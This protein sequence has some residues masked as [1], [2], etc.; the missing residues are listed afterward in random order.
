MSEKKSP[1]R[2][3]LPED[4]RK[5]TKLPPIYVTDV[6]RARV[7]QMAEDSG[8]DFSNYGRQVFEDHVERV[9]GDPAQPTTEEE[10]TFTVDAEQRKYLQKLADTMNIG[11][12][13]Y[14]ARVAALSLARMDAAEAMDVIVKDMKRVV[15]EKSSKKK[16]EKSATDDELAA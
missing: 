1:G 7:V 3:E 6:F 13:N 11:D 8:E 12:V 15:Q 2:R 14:A 9:A 16:G 4:K 10:I 5:K